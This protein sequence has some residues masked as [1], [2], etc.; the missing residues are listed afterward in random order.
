LLQSPRWLAETLPLD[1]AAKVSNFI[2]K[3][4]LLLDKKLS[5][6]S[7]NLLLVFFNSKKQ[8]LAQFGHTGLDLY[9][10]TKGMLAE[11]CNRRIYEESLRMKVA[12]QQIS[13]PCEVLFISAYFL[14]HK[15]LPKNAVV[16]PPPHAKN[17]MD[18]VSIT[19]NSTFQF[20][21]MPL[22]HNSHVH[23]LTQHC[24]FQLHTI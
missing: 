9:V 1:H 8:N 23:T 18:V 22:V 24:N 14:L 10:T 5:N 4:V 3:Y 20:S 17:G 2:F 7:L 12:Q 19:Y 16:N 6:V 11:L 21:Q 15:A 13:V